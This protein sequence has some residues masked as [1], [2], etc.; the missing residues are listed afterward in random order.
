MTTETTS[1]GITPEV[2]AAI[3][4]KAGPDWQAGRHQPRDREAEIATPSLDEMAAAPGATQTKYR[5]T[6]ARV[7]R[8]GG[9]DGSKPPAPLTVW[10]VTADGLAEHIATDVRPY[11]LSG[12]AEVVVDLEAMSGYILAGFRTAG[13]FTLE[14]L[15]VAEGGAA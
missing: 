2:L 14:A 5:V 7:G 3:A 9:R 6:Y 10:A 12:G 15:Q 13:T 8:H 11:L 4:M 1:Q